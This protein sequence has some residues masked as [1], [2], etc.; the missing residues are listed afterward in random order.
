MKMTTG[1]PAPSA[2]ATCC[3]SHENCA[4]S[5]WTV[6]FSPRFFSI[7]EDRETKSERERRTEK[8]AR[9]EKEREKG[10]TRGVERKSRKS[11]FVDGVAVGP[12]PRRRQPQQHR[13]PQ[14]RPPEV[15][16]AEGRPPGLEVGCVGRLG[17]RQRRREAP[18][19]AVVPKPASASA[20]DTVFSLILVFLVGAVPAVGGDREG[21]GE[22]GEAEPDLVKGGPFEVVVARHERRGRAE[23]LR[24]ARGGPQERPRVLEAGGGP[25]R[26]G[27][28]P[29]I[30]ELDKPRNRFLLLS[31]LCL[32]FERPREL[33]LGPR[34]GPL[35]PGVVVE[36]AQDSEPE[37]RG[38]RGGEAE[39]RGA[40]KGSGR[41]RRRRRGAGGGGRKSVVVVDCRRRSGDESFFSPS[42]LQLWPPE[43]SDPHRDS[44]ASSLM[45]G[46]GSG[47]RS[48]SRDCSSSSDGKGAH[49]FFLCRSWEDLV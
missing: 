38:V 15:A 18:P 25:R 31:F 16:L 32:V 12:E 23:A 40:R 3:S 13:G 8:T 34:E 39:G 48:S 11:T 4:P 46:K 49:F 20:S 22:G 17:G 29:E 27:R 47:G 45:H 6:F 1:R 30:P 9:K 26:E 43:K 21:V 7:W 14:L 10:K 44:N 24:L 36:V 2:S 41:R 28:G 35:V 19:P 37:P 5:R 42:L 33:L